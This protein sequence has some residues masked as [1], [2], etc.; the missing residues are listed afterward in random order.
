MNH[1]QIALWHRI[2][3]FE[4]DAVDAS[5]N[6]SNRLAR[7]NGWTPV[8][9]KRVIDEY[10]KFTFL[11]V[12]AGH[13]VTPSKAVDEAWHLHLLYTQSYWE[14]FCPLVLGQPLHHQ[15][16]NGDQEQDMKFQNWY[17][18]TLTSYER[19]F[20]ESPPADIWPR[21][22]QETKPKRRW[23]AFLPLFLLT[24]C[25]KSMNPLEWPGPAFLPFFFTLCLSAVGLA[26]AARH[27]LRGPV[28]G[29]PAAD[30]QLHPNELAYLNG[31][32]QLAILTAVARLTAAKRIEV[33]QKSGR[34]RLLDSTPMNDPLLDRIILRATDTTGGILPATLYQVTKPALYEMEI[35]LRRQG[36]W[37]SGLDTVKVQLIP[38]VIASLPLVVGITKINVGMMRERPVGFLI[39]LCLVLFA[40]NLAFLVKPRR[41]RYGDQVLKDLQS[42]LAGYRGIGRTRN[43]NA[44]DLGFGLA[45]FGFA[46]LAGS[47][48]EYLRRTM[49]QSSPYSS[50]GDGG[51]SSS[52]GGGG[53][54]GGGG[55]GGCGGS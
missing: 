40:V 18:N 46:A 21:A 2:R 32:P 53:G 14:Q 35:N 10:K 9:A 19:L 44:D 51:S 8:Y 55:C 45:L 50:G 38:F 36:L 22:N 31:G 15:P 30:W 12:A 29:P 49:A 48:H 7:E 4:I 33:N 25:D 6:Y 28:T 23:L 5:K 27:L 3:D 13:G 26:L 24:G 39:V 43:A 20:N 16:S 54:C 17:Q 42:N 37:V 11:A 34:L 47:E 52:C 1:D 41:S